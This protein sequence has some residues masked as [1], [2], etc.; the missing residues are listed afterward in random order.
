MTSPE[1]GVPSLAD[2]I[3]RLERSAR[4]TQAAVLVLAVLA[5]FVGLLLPLM[6]NEVGAETFVLRA[7]GVT[8]A[9]LTTTA[10]TGA[11]ALSFFDAN[12]AVRADLSL[13]ADGSP[14]LVLLDERGRVRGMFRLTNEGVPNILF[15]DPDGHPKAAMGLPT[16][17]IPALVLLGDSGR[18]R[19]M[20]P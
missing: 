13:R 20:T 3:A 2:R 11:P 16:D 17:G 1:S 14:G 18:V 10:E 6:R 15:T 5:V 8:R 4:R 12:G 19:Y 9:L 7:G